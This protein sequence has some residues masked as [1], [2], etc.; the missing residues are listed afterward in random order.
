VQGWAVMVYLV[1]SSGM[2]R[3]KA[4]KRRQHCLES[5]FFLPPV[6]FSSL[7]RRYGPVE[8]NVDGHIDVIELH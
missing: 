3:R 2:W 7:N 6:A 1:N 5:S 4:G 8:G